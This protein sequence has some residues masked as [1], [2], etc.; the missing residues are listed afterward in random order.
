MCIRDRSTANLH[1]TTQVFTANVSNTNSTGVTWSITEGQG[2]N[3]GG[4]LS[5]TTGASTTYTPPN[6]SGTYHVVATSTIDQTKQ[7]TVA[8]VVVVD[9]AVTLNQT[10]AAVLL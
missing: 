4:T 10:T 5:T 1:N 9:I 3:A 6:L 2:A 7:G 8:V